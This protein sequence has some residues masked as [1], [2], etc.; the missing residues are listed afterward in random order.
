MKIKNFIIR[1]LCVFFVTLIFKNYTYANVITYD[2]DYDNDGIHDKIEENKINGILHLTMYLSSVNERINYIIKPDDSEI[3]PSIHKSYKK[4]D[5]EV[6]STYYSMGGQVYSEVY[7]W[8]LNEKQFFLT[9]VITGERADP[10]SEVFFPSLKIDRVKCCRVLGSNE[11]YIIVPDVDVK[12]EVISSLRK[13][14]VLINEK[15]TDDAISGVSI[16]DAIEYADI[17]DDNNVV[18]L[19]DLA[20]F[21]AKNDMISSGIILEKIVNNYPSRVVAKLNLADVYWELGKEYNK[22]DKSKQLYKEYKDFMIEKG[23]GGKIPK[24]VFVRLSS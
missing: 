8:F 18:L 22:Y 2:Y 12:K 7:S 3:I 1:F 5:I 14:E 10:I 19:N 24:R 17:L 21:L 9:R 13:I 6:D 23:K 15:K 4:G 20:F 16:Y 11:K